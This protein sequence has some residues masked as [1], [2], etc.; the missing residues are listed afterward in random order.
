MPNQLKDSVILATRD[1]HST[2]IKITTCQVGDVD[3]IHTHMK[4]FLEKNFGITDYS[5]HVIRGGKGEIIESFVV[6]FIDDDQWYAIDTLEAPYDGNSDEGVSYNEPLTMRTLGGLINSMI[7]KGFLSFDDESLEGHGTTR[8]T[9]PMVL[10]AGVMQNDKSS[11]AD[12]THSIKHIATNDSLMVS[13]RTITDDEVASDIHNNY[14]RTRIMAESMIAR[15]FFEID[16]IPESAE[17][18][19]SSD[20]LKIK[21]NHTPQHSTD[22][23]LG[24]ITD[25][26]AVKNSLLLSP[27]FIDCFKNISG[28]VFNYE[29][30][31]GADINNSK[32]IAYGGNA[33]PNNSTLLH[34]PIIAI[35]NIDTE[36]N[37]SEQALVVQALDENLLKT[38]LYKAVN[39]YL[40]S[41]G[42]AE[43]FK[44]TNTAM[45]T[46]NKRPIPIKDGKGSD[47]T[48]VYSS[49]D[50]GEMLVC[51]VDEGEINTLEMML[52]KVVKKKTLPPS[53]DDIIRV[54]E[55]TIYSLTIAEKHKSDGRGYDIGV[56]YKDTDVGKLVNIISHTLYAD[57]RVG[58]TQVLS[59]NLRLAFAAY[60]QEPLVNIG[61]EEL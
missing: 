22:L 7:A 41:K 59:H 61:I 52:C 6:K 50:L 49:T 26:T 24:D 35:N 51:I 48:S 20:Y 14:R 47:I 58:N 10:L 32:L 39:D 30:R 23:Y 17:P 53:S 16:P 27:Q 13:I 21:I 45:V 2:E 37:L 29:Y 5:R 57:R 18:V 3:G 33:K 34:K 42:N 56:I 55:E 4:E 44:V 54:I 28:R 31:V 19:T 15:G 12:G 1:K 9:M 11:G 8:D 43:V 46:D 38:G 60:H 40:F 25:R 36:I